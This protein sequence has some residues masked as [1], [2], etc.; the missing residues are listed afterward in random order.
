M[1]HVNYCDY[2][3]FNQDQDRIFRPA[4]SGDY[5]FLL[6]MTPMKVY[7]DGELVITRPGACLLYGPESRQDYR[8]VR[9][10]KNSYVHFTMEKE[11]LEY[12]QVPVDQVFYPG[13]PE[14][15]DEVVRGIQQTFLT[16]DCYCQE[17]LHCLGIQLLIAAFR[18][19]R[20]SEVGI[21]GESGLFE[22]FRKARLTMLSQCEK[23]WNLESMCC[24]ISLE[25][26]QFYRYYQEFFHISPKADLISARIE[27]AKVLLTNEALQVQQV[28]DLCGF[29]NASHFTRH[30]KKHCGCAPS[31]YA[32]GIV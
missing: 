15:L 11:E 19:S 32:A 12:Y 23:D 27:K 22:E 30:F 1:F 21:R 16:R 6:F 20:Q 24:L 25:K 17:E 28:A 9:Q 31:M 4:G 7:L 14:I 8:A 18:E 29:A 2:D 3:C 26:S 10:F 13:K 5:L